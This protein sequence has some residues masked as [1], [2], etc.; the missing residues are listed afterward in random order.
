VVAGAVQ[1]VVG[2]EREIAVQQAFLDRADPFPR[3][4]LVEGDPGIGKTTLW[5]H[6]LA[7]AEQQGYVV[8][9]S[10]PGGS[11]AEL[12]FAALR[13][14]LEWVYDDAVTLLPKPQRRALDVALLRSDAGRVAPERGVVAAAFLGAVRTLAQ[15]DPLLIAVDDLQWIDS[16]SA[17]ILEFALRRLR[18]E[19]VIVLA[20][21]R[22]GDTGP[23]LALEAVFPS[24]RIERL[25]VDPLSLG[26]VHRL[27]ADRLGVSFPRPTL[28][29]VHEL[30][31]GNPFYALEVARAL[32]R[33][34][35]HVAPGE[36]LPVPD[37]LQDLVR[38]RLSALPG[39]TLDALQFTAALSRPTITL[40]ARAIE[41]DASVLD[42][43]V[44]AHVLDVAEG[45]IQ[46]THPLLASSAYHMPGPGRR[47]AIHE[48]L[49]RIVHEPEER[50]RHLSLATAGPDA[51][52]AAALD[53]AAALARSRGARASAAELFEQ[54]SRLT[55]SEL[56]HDVRR[57]TA[58]AAYLH[59]ESGDYR[60][61][62]AMLEDVVSELPPGPERAGVVLRLGL[63]RSY[64]DDLHAATDLYL[65]AEREA[66]GD[67]LLRSGALNSVS[68]M[69]FRRRERLTE[70]A[71]HAKE[72]VRLARELGDRVLVADGL[73]QQV[74]V[75][76]TLGL[77][78]ARTTLGELLE[79]E[80]EMDDARLLSQPSFPAA[81]V[82]M[83]WEE[84]EWA[85][86]AYEE[87]LDRGRRSGEYA[88][89]PYVHVLAAQNECL[90]GDF[91]RAWSHAEAGRELAEQ[92]GEE[93]VAS[94]A[95][96]LGALA[97]A[98]RG[99][100]DEARAAGE[101]ALDLARKTHGTPTLLFAASALGLLELSLGRAQAAADH[102]A[103]IVAFA[104]R[105]RH[106][107]PGMTRFAVDHVE[108]LIEL[109]QL[110]EAT[111]VLDWYE[112]KAVQL[113]RGG[114]LGSALRCRGLLQAARRDTEGALETLERAVAEH[115]AAPLPFERARTL[116]AQGATLR[117]AKRKRPA[118][119][120]LVVAQSEFER[121][122]ARLWV[123]RTEAELA[124]IAGRAG[125]KGGLTPT[126]LRVATLVAEGLATKE[127][128]AALFVSPKTVE[129]H[130]SKIYGKLGIRSRAELART[131]PPARSEN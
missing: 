59:F 74:L 128:A 85:R 44:Q 71:E 126:E 4:L 64:D 61:G 78:D 130:L 79:L 7:T 82:R 20:T 26:A 28:R 76:A 83:W 56:T 129:G 95:L 105:E 120:V 89:L 21:R 63:M 73:G 122:G 52:V 97:D 2:R 9:V 41:S 94:Y 86:Q 119:E 32:E 57:R 103:P 117:R 17:G 108:A 67:L 14:L 38:D 72:A 18:D 60:R 102:L 27:L 11:D 90:R 99:R 3:A 8:L 127:V 75:E 37:R 62:R 123:D 36:G 65:Q 91:E 116:L 98:H 112:T 6:A 19:H 10:K 51:E 77:P 124:R 87:L 34:G 50:A 49:A 66:G 40:V 24:G 96:A 39:P 104:R 106:G 53:E 80:P 92:A 118:R 69:L 1:E 93:T 115:D 58:E 100:T 47:R 55:P 31:G 25:H 111:D 30:S 13:D 88:L 46:F 16:S 54:A 68:A 48:V 131:Y 43:A 84:L 15:R 45:R 70:A 107:E 33:R 110:D 42:P 101:R 5:Q 22:A 12:G 113:R 121:L 35:R 29:R 109:G 23:T 114:A 81:I 125:S